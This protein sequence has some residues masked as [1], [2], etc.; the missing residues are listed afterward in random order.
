MPVKK[1][2]KRLNDL[3]KSKNLDNAITQTYTENDKKIDPISLT[4]NLRNQIV[5][6]ALGLSKTLSVSGLQH[7]VD[8]VLYKQNTVSLSMTTKEFSN[9]SKQDK[10][11]DSFVLQKVEPLLDKLDNLGLDFLRIHIR[12]MIH[13]LGQ[14]LKEKMLFKRFEVRL[15]EKLN[16]LANQN[17]QNLKNIQVQVVD[18]LDKNEIHTHLN[19]IKREYQTLKRIVINTKNRV[20]TIFHSDSGDQNTTFSLHE[21]NFLDHIFGLAT[22]LDYQ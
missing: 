18:A 8:Q 14:D 4:N 9:Q 17:G 12:D 19:S 5:G 20:G 10:I 6:Q 21:N 2:T 13:G 7:L 3:F 15:L 16:H 22:E 1:K 11:K